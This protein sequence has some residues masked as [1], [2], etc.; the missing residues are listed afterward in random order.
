MAQ[1]GDWRLGLMVVLGLIPAETGL[2]D[3]ADGEGAAEVLEDDFD[4]FAD[5]FVAI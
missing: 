5:V 1:P 3:I 2:D 4:A